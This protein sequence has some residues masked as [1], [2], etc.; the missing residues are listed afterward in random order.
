[1]LLVLISPERWDHFQSEVCFLGRLLRG[2]I[3]NFPP[4]R[5]DHFPGGERV[6][7]NRRP[8]GVS[9]LPSW[10]YFHF[11]GIEQVEDIVPSR[12]GSRE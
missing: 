6:L 9:P 1:V 3:A 4:V 7:P 8:R 10:S 12:R 11:C 2:C 5:T